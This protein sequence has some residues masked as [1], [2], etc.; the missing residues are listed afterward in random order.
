M[1]SPTMSGWLA[2]LLVVASCSSA[3]AADEVTLFRV[4][5]TDGSELVSY[6]EPAHIGDRLVFSI[7]TAAVADPPLQLVDIAASR[8]NW[9]RTDRYAEA[10]RA[11]HYAATQ[12]E[13]D[14]AALSVRMTEALNQLTGTEDAA[15]RL[16]IAEHARKMLAAWPQDHYN[17]RLA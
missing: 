15:R 9:E 16:A 8:V 13:F 11:A 10:A 14:Y 5:L 1:N 12:G 2:A 3:A 17:Y 6:G 4:F 7:P